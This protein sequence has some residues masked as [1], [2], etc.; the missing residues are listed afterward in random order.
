[1]GEALA[2]E[3]RVRGASLPRLESGQALVLSGETTVAGP[4]RGKGGRNLE[5]VA[6]WLLDA[7]KPEAWALVSGASDGLD[8]SSKAAGAM[9]FSGDKFDDKALREALD[10]HDTAPWFSE[11]QRL[12]PQHQ[13]I[14][15]IGDLLVLLYG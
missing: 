8:G 2:G 5:L 6:G 13:P 3:A 15:H 7:N 14:C 1:M 12:L 11:R 4:Y 10:Q 9:G